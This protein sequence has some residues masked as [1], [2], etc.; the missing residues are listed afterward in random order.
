MA[1]QRP[2]ARDSAPSAQ[3]LVLEAMSEAEFQREVM[4]ALER[5]NWCAW[6][7]PDSRRMRSGLPDVIAVHPS[8]PR[9]VCLE[10]KGR[11]TPITDTQR[12][13]IQVM[14]RIPGVYARIVRPADWPA[15]LEEIDSWQAVGAG[16]EPAP[17]GMG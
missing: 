17:A 4:E 12:L 16:V 15:V 3:D 10:L 9:L 5:R 7:V 6:H 2:V 13:V 8:I 11:R 14:A 1:R